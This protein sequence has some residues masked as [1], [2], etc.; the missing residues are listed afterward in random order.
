MDDLSIVLTLMRNHIDEQKKALVRA[1][2]IKACL[3]QQLKTLQHAKSNLP[4][5][6]PVSQESMNG[7]HAK[8]MQAFASSK[9]TSQ[10]ESCYQ[11]IPTSGVQEIPVQERPQLTISNTLQARTVQELPP[12]PLIEYLTTEEFT[13]VPNYMKGRI[14]YP[15]INFFVEELN[16][17]FK[18]KYKLLKQKKSSLS[19]PNRA[20]YETLKM[21][22]SKDTTGVYFVLEEDMKNWSSIKMSK[23]TRC[24]ITILRHCGRMCEIRSGGYL[25]YALIESY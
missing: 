20:R 18:A 1:E 24:L 12:C 5:H 11:H 15:Q 4:H 8:N 3:A 21:Q 19:E 9:S 6:L 25:R 23:E 10:M 2:N 14:T 13:N 22:E 16:K 7:K 17:V